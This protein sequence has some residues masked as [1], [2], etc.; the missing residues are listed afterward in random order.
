MLSVY[1]AASIL[2]RKSI[3]SIAD[4]I[5]RIM[6]KVKR[7]VNRSIRRKLEKKA[8]RTIGRY[9]FALTAFLGAL[10]VSTGFEYSGVL[11]KALMVIGVLL[12]LKGLHFLRGKSAEMVMEW[13]LKVPALHLRLLALGQ[14]AFGAYLYFFLGR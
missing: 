11:P 4:I 14:I 13:L 3:L 8:R 10:R 5:E 9:L 7:E 6:Q 2:F 12:I 1:L